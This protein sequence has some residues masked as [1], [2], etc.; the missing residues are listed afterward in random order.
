MSKEVEF[1][2]NKGN[3][4]ITHVSVTDKYHLKLQTYERYFKYG[5]KFGDFAKK[6]AIFFELPKF[7]SLDLCRT[8]TCLVR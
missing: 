1:E 4:Y 6:N 3:T 8:L 7:R 2:T 5:S